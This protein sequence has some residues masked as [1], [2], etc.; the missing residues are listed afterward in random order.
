MALF[1][2]CLVDS[3]AARTICA[4]HHK[5]QVEFQGTLRIRTEFEV[6]CAESVFGHI[7][8]VAWQPRARAA[9]ARRGGLQR[10][11]G[12]TRCP[13]TLFWHRAINWLR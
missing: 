11:E 10:R 7:P 1:S 2:L 4:S 8:C 12:N 13:M 3:S 6:R 9:E 5:E